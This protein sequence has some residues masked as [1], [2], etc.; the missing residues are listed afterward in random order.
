MGP[1]LLCILGSVWEMTM[2]T[3]QLRHECLTLDRRLIVLT[4]LRGLI[5][6]LTMAL[7]GIGI[8]CI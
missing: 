6:L 4:W 5:G 1:R 3:E 8:F 7:L 2:S